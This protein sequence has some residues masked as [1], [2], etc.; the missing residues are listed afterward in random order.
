MMTSDDLMAGAIRPILV[1]G[2]VELSRSRG[3][4][5][6]CRKEALLSEKLSWP[7]S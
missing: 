2:G 5:W 1:G 4:C 6:I 7:F 3:L